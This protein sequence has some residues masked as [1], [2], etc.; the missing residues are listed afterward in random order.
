[1]S[2]LDEAIRTCS[3]GIYRYMIDTDDRSAEGISSAIHRVLRDHL[4]R[5]KAAHALADAV[6][7]FRDAW[8]LNDKEETSAEMMRRVG[9]RDRMLYALAAFDKATGRDEAAPGATT[10]KPGT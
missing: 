1:M 3:E 9:A 4:I 2:D 5:G 7:E 6:R 8:V 10:G